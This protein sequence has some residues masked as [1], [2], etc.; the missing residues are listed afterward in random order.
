MKKPRKH[1]SADGEAPV[2]YETVRE[3][4]REFPGTVEG[5]S[6]GTPA[7]HVGK[8]LLVRQHQDGESLVMKIDFEDRAMR[9][10]ADPDT[11]HIT[12]H[13]RNYPWMLVRLA[14]VAVEDLR[15]LFEEAWRK[16]AEAPARPVRS[17]TS[18]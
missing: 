1:G 9:M 14:T 18:W 3:I 6:Y 2:T 4:A 13:Y 8:S 12:E 11:F 10:K 7:I 15:E 17:G 5:K 16:S